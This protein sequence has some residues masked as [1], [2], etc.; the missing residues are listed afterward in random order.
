[1][2]AVLPLRSAWAQVVTDIAVRGNVRVDD[3]SIRPHIKSEA[4]KPLS[5]ET[6]DNDIK[7]LYWTGYFDQVEALL[8]PSSGGMR[9][10]FEV[11]ERPAIRS[12]KL[13]GNKEVSEKDLKEQLAVGTRRFLDRKKINAAIEQA[14]AFYQNKGLY[15]T[16]IEYQIADAG[17]NEVDLTFTV[18]EGEK[19]VIREVV[20]EGSTLDSS[21]LQK[22]VK[23]HNY[24]WWSSWI[25]GSGV[26]REEELANDVQALTNYYLTH[27][28]VDVKVGEPTVRDIENGLQVVFKV[29]EGQVFTFGAISATGTL[30]N[31]SVEQTLNNTKVKSGET[32]DIEKLRADAFA[33]SDKFTDVGYAFA[34]VDPV[35]KVNRESKT[36][37]VDFAVDK[38]DV[39]RVNRINISGNSKTR[40]NVIRRSM[41]IGEQELFSSS[42][43][44]RS[45]ELLQRLG[46]FDEVTITP[47][48]SPDKEALD[49]NVAVREGS[50][51]S[52]SIGAGV[53]SG[54][55]FLFS[56]RIAENNVFGTGRSVSLDI[57]TGTK[58]D[59]FVLSVDDPRV[60]DS[61]WSSGLDL[62]STQSQFDQFDRKQTGGGVSA[63]YPLRLFSNED[64][65]DLRFTLGYELLH[66]DISDIDF[67]APQLVKDSEGSSVSSSIKPKIVRNTINNPLDPSSG[68]K[69]SLG[70]EFAGLGGDQE[71]WLAEAASTLYYPLWDTK[72]GQFV[73]SQRTRVGWGESYNDDPFPLFK[74]YFPGGINSVRGYEAREMGPKDDNGNVFGGNKELILNF[75]LLYP[76]IASAGL[77][78]VI[79]YDAGNAYD[80]NDSLDISGLR[81]AI[82]WGIRWRS[83]LA[84]IRIEIGYPLDKESGDKSMVLN[85]SFGA[86]Q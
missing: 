73:F 31:G 63:G 58:H 84:P 48:P 2:L 19:K 55:G 16:T 81:Q 21:D 1:M 79:F 44:K 40:E 54:D 43:I 41:R 7:Q 75:E 18:T 68:S 12:I 60:N 56:S 25:T 29:D 72:I 20:F 83:P 64:E 45:Q 33:I 52:F 28:Y 4:G 37:D 57:N 76:L 47:N 69:Q 53:S 62:L 13:V 61:Q 8:E 59:N 36:V 26:V 5:R 22:Q 39:V 49:L 42:K 11:K 80:D 78:G 71:F 46:Y 35:T 67:D 51:G 86:P 3:S 65:D 10:V 17:S 34:N 24:R 85:F 14:K 82:G 66:I 74:R 50:T 77:N 23:T 32:F 38:G 30:L 70:L 27:G 9:L 15:G 6:L